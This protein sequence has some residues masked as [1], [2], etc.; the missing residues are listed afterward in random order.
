[1]PSLLTIS[2]PYGFGIFVIII[3]KKEF[4]VIHLVRTKFEK[5]TFLTPWYAHIRVPF[6]GVRNVSFSKNFAY[7]LNGWPLRIMIQSI[8]FWLVIG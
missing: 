8:L 3:C 2:Y 4:S 7:V 1:M 5:L 6:Q